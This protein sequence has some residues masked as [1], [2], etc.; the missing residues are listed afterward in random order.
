M[1]PQAL[2]TFK[3]PVK[4]LYFVTEASHIIPASRIG[5]MDL[6]HV[7]RGPKKHLKTLSNISILFQRLATSFQPAGS[8]GWAEPEGAVGPRN[9]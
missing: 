9:I 1:A 7:S 5:W 3:N 2:E 6:A 8:V 4:P